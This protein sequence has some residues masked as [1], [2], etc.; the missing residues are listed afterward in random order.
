L[1]LPLFSPVLSSIGISLFVL[2]VAAIFLHSFIKNQNMAVA[3]LSVPAALLQLWGYGAGF[4][5]EKLK[6]IHR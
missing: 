2:Y 6:I 1:I 3:L 4:L 5:S